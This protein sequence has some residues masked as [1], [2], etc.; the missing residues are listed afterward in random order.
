LFL[1]QSSNVFYSSL[2]RMLLLDI[3]LQHCTWSL[4]LLDLPPLPHKNCPYSDEDKQTA[5]AFKTLKPLSNGKTKIPI[6]IIPLRLSFHFSTMNS[7]WWIENSYDGRIWTSQRNIARI[8]ASIEYESSKATDWFNAQPNTEFMQSIAQS[9]Q[10]RADA[11]RAE[12]QIELQ[13]LET[14]QERADGHFEKKA[15]ICDLRESNPRQR[16]E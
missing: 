14:L 8:R 12:L 10:N 2:S 11:F 6:P 4:D 3:W 1:L 15:K 5:E 16:N 7:R 9:F 13:R